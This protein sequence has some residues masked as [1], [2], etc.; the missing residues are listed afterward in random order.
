MEEAITGSRLRLGPP[1]RPGRADIVVLATGRNQSSL[2]QGQQHGY[3]H[4]P[5]VLGLQL[6]MKCWTLI[7]ACLF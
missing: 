6:K 3:N 1:D 4:K 5:L 7:E 2:Q